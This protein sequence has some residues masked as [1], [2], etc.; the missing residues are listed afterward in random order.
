MTSHDLLVSTV[1]VVALL[2][3][4]LVGMFLWLRLLRSG[5]FHRRRQAREEKFVEADRTYNAMITSEA[6]SRELE[7]KGF[8]SPQAA[9]LIEE[10]R[11]AYYAGNPVEAEALSAQA[12]AILQ[13]ALQ[14]DHPPHTAA[15]EEVEIP[16][17][18]PVLGK[19]FPEHYLEAKFLLGAIEG[20]VRRTK[21]DSK[22][23]KKARD[24]LRKART[25]YE[26]ED[27]AHALTHALR[28]RRLL[29]GTA[30]RAKKPRPKCPHCG[31]RVAKVDEFCGKCGANLRIPPGCRRCETPLEEEDR[32][33]R[34]CGAP[35]EVPAQTP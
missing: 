19:K 28:C 22:R 26:K 25:A 18:K 35:A 30:P 34:K 33:C 14:R 5:Y 32:F 6:I 15:K 1:I 17:R 16:D 8:R 23:G 2:T 7:E 4:A 13:E 27:Y 21:K 20:R 12:R 9:T 11:Q 24:L 3:V 29:D 31:A 10:A